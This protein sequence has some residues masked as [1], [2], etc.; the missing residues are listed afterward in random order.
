MIDIL[1]SGVAPMSTCLACRLPVRLRF[2]APAVGAPPGRAR[3]LADAREWRDKDVAA[4]P[5]P[6]RASVS[7]AF[8]I[9]DE[10]AV[11]HHQRDR[12]GSPGRSTIGCSSPRWTSS[13]GVTSCCAPR[14]STVCRWSDPGVAGVVEV[15]DEVEIHVPVP[16]TN[17]VASS[18]WCG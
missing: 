10:R 11:V 3:S 12:G 7:P 15:V 2:G 17:S 6:A 9:L 18:W 16:S 4:L 8:T 13:S 5:V 1:T 14:S